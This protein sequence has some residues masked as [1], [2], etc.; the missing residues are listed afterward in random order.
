MIAFV[1]KRFKESLVSLFYLGVLPTL[2]QSPLK[3]TDFFLY[4]YILLFFFF[5]FFS[6][7]LLSISAYFTLCFVASL[8]FFFY[9]IYYFF[10]VGL[11]HFFKSFIKNY[12]HLI[13]CDLFYGLNIFSAYLNTKWMHLLQDYLQPEKNGVKYYKDSTRSLVDLGPKK[14][15]FMKLKSLFALM[16]VLINLN[17]VKFVSFFKRKGFLD[18]EPYGQEPVVGFSKTY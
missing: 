15:G 3:L 5:F 6:I 14:G 4:A 18:L 1:L 2:Q 9:V 12:I 13:F 7:V 17:N 11:R 16:L 8:A 10:S